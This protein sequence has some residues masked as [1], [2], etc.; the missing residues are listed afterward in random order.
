MGFFD[1]AV[2]ANKDTVSA[3][4]CL[5]Q[6][7]LFSPLLACFYVVLV[8]FPQDIIGERK[9]LVEHTVTRFQQNGK[10]V[11]EVLGKAIGFR[12]FAARD[13]QMLH[14]GVKSITEVPVLWLIQQVIHVLIFISCHNQP[15][16][17]IR[18]SIQSVRKVVEQNSDLNEADVLDFVND[19]PVN[20]VLQF[21][22]Q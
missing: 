22:P 17:S 4:V 7:R 13:F 3:V 1:G 11:R 9:H 15:E 20:L 18:V 5:D 14:P 8:E 12:R 10:F 19:N 16:V 6:F 2:E 21:F